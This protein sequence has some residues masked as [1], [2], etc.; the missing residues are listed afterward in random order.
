MSKPVATVLT[1][2]K[3]RRRR[4]EYRV[5]GGSFVG[6]VFVHIVLVIVGLVM[7]L[8]FVHELAKSLSFPLRVQVGDVVFWPKDFTFRNYTYFID[9]A[10]KNLWRSF[11]N[12]A[13]LTVVGTVWSVFFT[14]IVAFPLSRPRSEFR[15]GPAMMGLVVFSIIFFPPLI[16]YFLV[17]KSYG[18]MDTLWAIILAHTIGPFNLILV[19]SYYRGLPEDLFDSCRIDGGTDLRLVWQIAIPLSKP[20]LATI[21]V[22]TA[23]LLWNIFLHALLF[24]RDP[25]IM[26]LQPI[27]RSILSRSTDSLARQSLTFNPFES[28]ES[29][30]SAIILLST[31]PIIAVYP[32]LQRYFVKG[33][34]LGALKS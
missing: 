26:P 3:A 4:H 12:T 13:Y 17:V 28:A 18:L 23:V 7:L 14:A 29:T 21:A 9:P 32:F 30:K 20:V 10:Y 22:Y 24:I 31:L 27:V 5:L 33:A 6:T 25:T 11:I 8:P 19:F 2:P 1:S 16:P 34:L 15:L